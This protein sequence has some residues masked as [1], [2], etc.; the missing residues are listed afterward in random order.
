MQTSRYIGNNNDTGQILC[1]QNCRH[2]DSSG[3]QA[4]SFDFM[5]TMLQTGRPICV[6]EIR[7]QTNI[8]SKNTNVEKYVDKIGKRCYGK[9][10]GG[11]WQLYVGESD[12]EGWEAKRGCCGSDQVVDVGED[13]IQ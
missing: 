6:S 9:K 3:T 10:R 13:D 12:Y 5:Q 1:R 4:Y 11:G 8:Q 7:M 2:V